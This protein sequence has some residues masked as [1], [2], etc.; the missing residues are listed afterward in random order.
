MGGTTVRCS[1]FSSESI[2]QIHGILHPDDRGGG[3]GAGG[4]ACD[5]ANATPRRNSSREGDCD[6]DAGTTAERGTYVT[7]FWFRGPSSR[8]GS[9][10]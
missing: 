6:V 10:G 3:G 7:G 9:G 2:I 8:G 4:H 5:G 1:N